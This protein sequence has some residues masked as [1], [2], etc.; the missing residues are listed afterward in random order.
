MEA[1]RET[2]VNKVL[3]GTPMAVVAKENSIAYSTLARWVKQAKEAPQVRA[4]AEIEETNSYVNS[5][6]SI[7]DTIKLFHEKLHQQIM[8]GSLPLNTVSG[9]ATALKTLKEIMGG[10]VDDMDRLMSMLSEIDDD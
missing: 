10:T 9:V 8:S 6:V 1:D 5:A 7:D 4:S 3:S 2:I